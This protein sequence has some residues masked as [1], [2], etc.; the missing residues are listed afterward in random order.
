MF[1]KAFCVSAAIAVV[2]SVAGAAQAG[3]FSDREA[4][5]QVSQ[6]NETALANR[7]LVDCWRTAPVEFPGISVHNIGFLA[8]PAGRA[9]LITSPDGL[10]IVHLPRALQP[11]QGVEVL[12]GGSRS[13]GRCKA[14]LL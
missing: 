12:R 14:R 6:T 3:P 2:A 10:E 8:I 1:R 9:V 5:R 13:P 4:Y 11:G 7:M